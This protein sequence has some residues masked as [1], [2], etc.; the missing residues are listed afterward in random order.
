MYGGCERCGS[1]GDVGHGCWRDDAPVA[2][3]ITAFRY[4][5]PVAAAIVAAKARGARAVWGD[6]GAEL[7][8][9]VR[10][11][12][13]SPPPDAVTWVPTARD[14]V[15]SRGLD[16]AERLATP[17]ASA[18]D[19]PLVPLLGAARRRRDQTDLPLADRRRLDPAAFGAVARPPPRVLL[20]DDVLTT[21]AT[22]DVAAGAL[23][24]AGARPVTLAVLA[25]A[26][27]HPL[28]AA[29]AIQPGQRRLARTGWTDQHKQAAERPG[30]ARL[31]EPES[32]RPTD[33]EEPRG[34]R[35]SDPDRYRRRS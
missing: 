17:V 35:R 34:R 26:G 29:Q 30:R 23:V 6:L 28:G 3:T 33:P 16:H 14:Q 12:I 21:G 25:R 11:R 18:L 4:R 31:P 22:I 27:G 5:G 2:A 32:R 20:V 15:R 8:A 19:V 13:S 9:A 24:R 7:A 1:R 10:A